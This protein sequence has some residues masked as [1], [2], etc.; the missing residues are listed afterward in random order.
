MGAYHPFSVINRMRKHLAVL[1]F[2]GDLYGGLRAQG[3]TLRWTDSIPWDDGLLKYSIVYEPEH[4]RKTRVLGEAIVFP[5]RKF[6]IQ[7]D[8][9]KTM[10]IGLLKPEIPMC[11]P[12]KLTVELLK[13]GEKV[14]LLLSPTKLSIEALP[15]PNAV[16]PGQRLNTYPSVDI[17]GETRYAQA[18]SLLR[19][20]FSM[21]T[22]HV[23]LSKSTMC[24]P[25]D[26]KEPTYP[27]MLANRCNG[28]RYI[29]N[30]PVV[31]NQTVVVNAPGGEGA[32]GYLGN[33][34]NWGQDGTDGTSGGQGSPGKNGGRGGDVQLEIR[35]EQGNLFH[36]IVNGAGPTQTHII[37]FSIGAGIVVNLQG[38]TGG[39][40]GKG[41]KGGGGGDGTAATNYCSGRDPG[42]GGDGGRGGDGGFG[43]N[44]GRLTVYA[45][46]AA[47]P[48]LHLIKLNNAGGAGGR[49][50]D[51]GGGG[52]GGSDPN[53]KRLIDLLV[54]GRRGSRG[55]SGRDGQPGMS[56]P[57]MD[58]RPL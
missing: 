22:E 51:G 13:T 15:Y 6:N 56:G 47:M 29:F 31:F 34:G 41:G 52:P 3:F 43:G 33:S 55:P 10:E 48:H 46:S 19:E 50:G 21:S 12:L 18:G 58:V 16:T 25:S 49:G 37:D 14:S 45:D 35:Q 42:L 23:G 40:G 20:Y 44:G 38:G 1:L 57:A 36:V 8:N 5:N 9:A 53:S 24:I 30:L 54:T 39:A 4:G 26:Y 7:C 11:K 2:L 32:D 17:N 27:V 28:E